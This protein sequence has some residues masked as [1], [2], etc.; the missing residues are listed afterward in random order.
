[1][2]AERTHTGEGR[3]LAD[4]VVEA[5]EAALAVQNYVSPLD[6][7][8]RIGWLDSGTVKRWRQGQVEDIES[9]IQTKPSRISEAIELLSEWAVVKELLPQETQY[10]AQTPQR[11]AL[12]RST[13]CK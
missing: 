5:A 3:P 10:V 13:S 8:T 1:M 2:P 11:Q 6:V 4:R 7:L 12:R 9:A